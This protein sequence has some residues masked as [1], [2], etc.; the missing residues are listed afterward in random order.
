MIRKVNFLIIIK[1]FIIGKQTTYFKNQ[2]KN[3]IK[4]KKSYNLK[5]AVK[6]VFKELRSTKKNFATVLFSPA[7][8]SYDQFN[9]FV[10]RGNQFKKVT[11]TYVKKF[12]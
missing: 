4:Y 10:E 7:S 8:A 5:N 1:S 3:K 2:I 9:N 6:D 12:L 11:K